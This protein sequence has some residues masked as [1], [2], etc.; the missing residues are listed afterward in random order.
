[1]YSIFALSMVICTWGLWRR[2]ELWSLGRPDDGRFKDTKRRLKIAWEQIFKQ[3]KTNAEKEPALF[4]S[5][6][7][8]GFLALL[9]TTTMVAID[10]DLGIHIYNGK[11]YLAIT[12]LS[13]ILGVCYLA[14]VL[15]A[16]HRR[17]IVAPDRLHNTNADFFFLFVLAAL[18][19]QGYILEGLRIYVT[20]DPW[21]V[22]SPVGNFVAKLSWFLSI[23]S[24]KWLHFVTWW[25]HSL[26][27]FVGIA[28]LPY[29]KLFHLVASSANLFFQEL[30]KP[31]GAMKNPGDIEVLMTEA[32]EKEDG[33]FKVGVSNALDL[34]WK[35]RME[36]DTCT[37]CGRCQDVCPAYNSGKMLSPKWMIL[38]TRDHLL[39]LS[40][41]DL[42]R[43]KK[44]FRKNFPLF[45]LL[46]QIDATLLEL[47]IL[48]SNFKRANNLLVQNE[49]RLNVGGSEEEKLGGEVLNTDVYWSCTTCRACVEVCP[50]GIEHVDMITDVRRALA[51]MEGDIPQEAQPILK[52]IETRGNPLG[53]REER[54]DWSK[55]LDVKILN[56]GDEVEVLYWVGCISA[57]DKR[58]QSIARSMVKILNASK[59]SWGILG[60]RECCTGDPAR[61][62]GE[63]NLFQTMVKQNTPTLKSVKFKTLVANCPHCFNSLKNEYPQFSGEWDFEVI[64]HTHFVN[65]LLA[66]KVIV[67]TNTK[68]LN[69]TFHDPCYLGRYNDTYDE[70]RET[71]VQIG[72]RKPKEMSMNRE[73]GL[74]CGAGG[75]HY[76]FD[77]KVG[78]RVNVKRVDQAA[79]TNADVIA[80]GCPFCLQMMEDGVKLTGREESL[81][82]RDIAELV[83]DSL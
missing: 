83:A 73:R 16:F 29:S 42:N 75:G 51:L 57:Y 19:V 33:E 24:A 48:P 81:V 76:W 65:K 72:G 50:V 47:L 28:L 71:L 18:A 36:V 77:M 6:I 13:D 43:E 68:D 58:K 38:D 39:R 59:M 23:E 31:K 35:Q 64:H 56:E 46:D 49:A 27:V 53:P 22:Y 70:P 80:T 45:R 4:H 37:S 25:I 26:T 3:R 74:C 8:I 82:V 30:D 61:R 15:I 17:Y 79:E 40:E 63:E 5:L 20:D 32:M 41:K 1:M 60:E 44:S 54:V 66:T 12:L 52:A 7:Y 67:P 55:G 69:I 78:E 62:I 21:R 10:H 9:F 2:V 34:T 11:Y 14:G